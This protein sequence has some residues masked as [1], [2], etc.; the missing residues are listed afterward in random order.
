VTEGLLIIGAGGHG[1]VVA[2]A[3]QKQGAWKRIAFLDDAYPATTQT[4]GLAVLGKTNDA[5]QALLGYH[6]ATVAIGNADIRLD[7]LERLER[8][9]FDLPVIQH[10][11]ATVS[12]HA[13][14]RPGCVICA[15][16]VVNP[17]AELDRGCIVNTGATVDH[18]CRLGAGVHVAPGAHLGGGV[19]VGERSWIGIGASV[20]AYLTIGARVTVDAGA[21]VVSDVSDDQI[22]AGAPVTIAPRSKR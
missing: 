3:A 8:L 11:E 19:R 9:G 13:R 14:L 7:L 18:D 22:V 6:D 1:K 15:Q 20:H 16:G 21:A 5:Q 4:I 10:P 2:D 17:D 12:P